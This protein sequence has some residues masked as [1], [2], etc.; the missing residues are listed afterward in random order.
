MSSHKVNTVTLAAWLF[1]AMT[2]PLAQI[3]AGE[4]WL[5]VLAVGIICSVLCWFI[6]FLSDGECYHAKWYCR[7]QLIFLAVA[8]G[9]VA[10]WTVPCWPTGNAFPVVPL[11]LLALAG[12]AAWNGAERASRTGGVVFWFVAL[13]YAI[14]LAAGVKNLHVGWMEPQWEIGNTMLVFVFLIPVAA[15]FLPREKGNGHFAVLPAVLFFGAAAALLTAG[16]LLPEVAKKMAFPFYEYS[17]SLSLLG[18][19]ER[20][21]AFVSVALTMGYFSL[22][23]LFLSGAWHLAEEI[24]TGCGRG[25]ILFCSAVAAIS[26]VFL[27]DIL[28]QWLPSAALAFWGVIPFVAYA[29]QKIKVKKDEKIA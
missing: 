9:I 3:A 1:A 29:A 20:F 13:L 12:A 25:G 8:A 19:A 10:N 27:P 11:V 21:E 17:K 22:L 18:V 24:R 28:V 5:F 16:A 6:H 23:S 15:L 2:A 14:I 26:L 4:S 7:V